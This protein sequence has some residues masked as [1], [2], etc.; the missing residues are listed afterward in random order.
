MRF[1]GWGLPFRV[2]A[3]AIIIWTLVSEGLKAPGY[4]N[5]RLSDV[6]AV[7]PLSD[8]L[9]LIAKKPSGRREAQKANSHGFL[10]PWKNWHGKNCVW[11]TR[12]GNVFNDER[13]SLDK[14]SCRFAA[15]TSFKLLTFCIVQ[16]SIDLLSL[17]RNFLRCHYCVDLSLFI[18]P[19]SHSSESGPVYL[20]R[21]SS[22]IW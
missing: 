18:P 22:R 13:I 10:N 3:D 8:C 17:N 21:F 19:S 4:S 9:M 14:S 1:W 7:F 11:K 20:M 5:S 15:L 12:N 2:F 6:F 16:A